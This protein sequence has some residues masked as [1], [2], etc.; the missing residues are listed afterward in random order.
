MRNLKLGV[1]LIGGFCL[2]AIIILV[3]GVI[4]I[5]QQNNLQEAL[6]KLEKDALIAVENMLSIQEDSSEV[7]AQTR[8]LLSPYIPEE[9]RKEVRVKIEEL[10]NDIVARQKALTQ[11][12]SFAGIKSE[13]Q[14]YLSTLK[15]WSDSNNKAIAFSNDLVA[16]DIANPEQLAADM[17][18]FEAAHKGLLNN[19]F[20][21]V[22]LQIPFDGGTDSNQCSLGRWLAKMPTSNP[23]IVAE[24]E[25]IR[26][27]HAEL[28]AIVAKIKKLEEND[29]IEQA[30]LLLENRL[31]PLSE[32]IFVLTHKVDSISQKHHKRFL[33]MTTILLKESIT[34]QRENFTILEDLV[35]KAQAYA[36]DTANRANKAADTGKKSLLFA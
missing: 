19:V 8:T 31:I 11:L 12:P 10:R 36:Q 32:E 26:P 1:K 24:M 34:H 22:F 33:K 5:V 35:D 2:T 17:L 29:Q 3:V 18:D 30:K 15:G 13:W 16:A 25:K 6:E 23:E 28:H 20:K 27:I 9:K 14:E 7:V 21:S 4:S